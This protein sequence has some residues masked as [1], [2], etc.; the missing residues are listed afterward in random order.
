M[1]RLI[2]GFA[3]LAGCVSA[4]SSEQ[5]GPQPSEQLVWLKGDL[6]VHD[7]HS[8]DG[9]LPRQRSRDRAKGNVPVGA[10]IGRAE[11]IGLDFLP[12]TDHR[13]FD[14]YYDP[15]WRSAK[16][17]LIP[18]EEANGSPHVTVQGTVDSIV[19]GA[20]RPDLSPF[21]HVQ[22]SVWD[23]HAQDAN[24]TVAHPDDGETND[25]GAPNA[26]A[27]VQ[28][29]DLVEIWNKAS[30]VEKEIAYSENRWN[31]G[32]RF[33]VAGA[34]DSHFREYWDRQ[35][36]GFPTTS[37]LAG[38]RSERGVI[39]ALKSGWTSISIKP[40]GPFIELRASIAGKQA[41]GGDEVIAKAGSR[42]RLSIHVQRA[43]GMQ[44]LLYRKP[45]RSA[46]VFREFAP[47][48]DDET[49]TVEIEAGAQPDWYRVE[50]RGLGFPVSAAQPT[51]AAEPVVELKAIASPIFF[52]PSLENASPELAI[53]PDQ[54]VADGAVD[55]F[56]TGGKGG[57]FS[58]FPDIAVSGG[59]VHVVAEE[60]DEA[61]TRIRYR[62]IGGASPSW[63]SGNGPARFPRIAA[64]GRD[65]W[66]VWQ[67]DETQVPHRPQ[68]KLRRSGD[69]GSTWG[70]VETLRALDGRAEH[71]D[72][73]VSERA[74]VG[75]VVVWQEMRDGGAFDVMMQEVGSG[76]GPRNMSAEGKVTSAG[77]P[78]DSR[79]ARFPASVWPAVAASPDG[80]VAVVWQDNRTDIDPLWTGQEVA[81]GTNPDNWQVMAA[82]RAIDGAW[83]AVDSMGAAD[84]ADRHPDAAFGRRGELVVAWESKGLA[85]AG[86]N[87]AVMAAVA[88][89]GAAFGAPVALGLDAKAMSQRARLGVDADGAVRAVWYDS[90]STDWRWRVMT[91][92]LGDTG[93]SAGALSPG[94][95]NNTW[96]ATSGGSIVFASTRNAK[97]MQRDRT[98]DIFVLRALP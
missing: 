97:R 69:G 1:R 90:R 91:A 56:G 74:S 27:S 24:W 49:F 26:L 96:P 18:G 2:L 35:G 7:D 75:P 40:D 32:F 29:V 22:Q 21:A 23:A 83:R 6:H 78:D 17:L 16:L 70:A 4:P 87:L 76:A 8:S 11:E 9:S 46:G 60:H 28:G 62:K 3:A 77:S 95:G 84:A 48:S 58:G 54:G 36:P 98:Q 34:S 25:D 73:A 67:E 30:D 42:G 51:P 37:V 12:L 71:P 94:K 64:R 57:G 86:R 88:R 68:V 13:T 20:G 52:S 81:A 14:Q 31:A 41:V 82:V 47:A 10:Q 55:V 19:Q 43:K 65:V 72:I 59:A 66:I 33:G 53:P 39:N 38:T 85:P 80:R 61:L 79:S 92:R 63:V 93:W 45:G 44:V 89:E 50:I 5:A 15:Q